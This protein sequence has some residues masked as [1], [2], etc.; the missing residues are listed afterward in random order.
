MV[1]PIQNSSPSIQQ[2]LNDPAIFSPVGPLDTVQSGGSTAPTINAFFGS[3]NAARLDLKTNLHEIESL[4]ARFHEQIMQ[5]QL[6]RVAETIAE[7]N[8]LL[9][10]FESTQIN[11]G[12]T[13]TLVNSINNAGNSANSKIT[14]V[15]DKANTLNGGTDD[16]NAA[17]DTFNAAYN[18]G[19]A[20]DAARDAA[21][22]NYN[23]AANSYNNKVTS[24]NNSVTQANL[25]ITAYN[26]A[27]TDY[28][29]QVDINNQ[30]ID[31]ENVNRVAQGLTPLPHQDHLP[32]KDP[33][34]T[35]PL[36]PILPYAPVTGP[37]GYAATVGIPTTI[38]PTV[39]P[40]SLNL[41]N[42]FLKPNFLP[43]YLSNVFFISSLT[44]IFGK[45]LEDRVLPNAG[46]AEIT[47]PD[48]FIQRDANDET[49]AGASSG[50]GLSSIA[51]GL[52]PPRLDA[53]M[54]KAVL[55]EL[56]KHLNLD[57]TPALVLQLRPFS[58]STFIRSNIRGA[59]PG[60]EFVQSDLKIANNHA[61]R[62]AAA[63]GSLASS[64]GFVKNNALERAFESVAS[65]DP[66]LANLS[67]QDR[68]ELIANG[69]SL[70]ATSVLNLSLGSTAVESNTPALLNAAD[71]ALITTLPGSSS[72]RFGT[73]SQSFGQLL[74]AYDT[75][76]LSVLLGQFLANRLQDQPL[77]AATTPE[78]I[79][80]KVLENLS[81]AGVPKTAA[82]LKTRIA[83]LVGQ[84]EN[85]N[86]VNEVFKSTV[87]FVIGAAAKR[88]LQKNLTE[89]QIGP[90][91]ASALAHEINQRVFGFSV[92]FNAPKVVFQ[93]DQNKNP[94]SV[95]SSLADE[96]SKLEK[97]DDKEFTQAVVD[98]FGRLHETVN[99]L[100]AFL[101]KVIDPGQQLFGLMYEKPQGNVFDGVDKRATDIPL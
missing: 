27:V 100:E 1:D 95:Q 37:I 5:E 31:A 49:Q 97:K 77:P 4:E 35:A 70:V 3:V 59:L 55:D 36:A 54:G 99:S 13:D 33:I 63:L 66:S 12:T 60:I 96:L 38:P 9:A 24:Y 6:N 78:E 17:V 21:I 20:D 83:G 65:K 71:A 46:T 69:G 18:A 90:K 57:T 23:A 26:N 39:V 29:N 76:T 93:N 64:L 7:Y 41:L 11:V 94:V 40:G 28:N 84:P 44:D 45:L 32:Y 30:A 73:V 75:G 10:L 16:Y 14:D 85:S 47:R 42:D 81:E 80:Q 51:T 92:D 86:V 34:P 74:S 98:D 50:I 89:Q 8:R 67:A 87:S 25:K 48:A 82:E 19:F 58:V 43:L 79:G 15:Q 56:V 61:V 53:I 88:E 68:A 22:D 91:G 2:I 62:I 52:D 72:A 101:R